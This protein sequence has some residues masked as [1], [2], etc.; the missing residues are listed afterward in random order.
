MTSTFQRVLDATGLKRAARTTADW[1]DLQYWQLLRNLEAVAPRT[2]GRLLDVGCGEKDF[3]PIFRPYVS[4][5]VGL[6]YADT[7][8]TTK[9]SNRSGKPDFYYDGKTFPFESQSFDTVIS[10]QVLEHTPD[11]RRL[12]HEIAR[13]V[14]KDGLVV[15]NA[16]FSFR[17]HEEPFDY[18]RYT[19]H[20][21]RALFDDAGLE[22][23]E[24]W[25]MGDLWSVI[26]HKF[27]SYLA[28]RV[29]RIEA[30]AQMMGKH[31]HEGVRKVS[32]RLWTFPMV[33]P[34]MAA[35]AAGARLLDRIAPDGT[36]ALS[37]Q[38]IGRPKQR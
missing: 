10:V 34:T 32:A 33:L 20:G 38:V 15:M 21:W 22:V 6:E 13:V 19:P 25:P 36:E 27:N 29:A 4:E 37:Y 8:E 1:V 12:I 24:I 23:T 3:E 26:G 31:G 2:R 18:F 5:Y 28:F 7:F 9:S 17:L 11:P 14:K 35:V 30:L 16:P